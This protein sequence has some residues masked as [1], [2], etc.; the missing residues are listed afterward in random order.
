[1]DVRPIFFKDEAGNDSD[2]T[3]LKLNMYYY[4]ANLTSTHF[5]SNQMKLA[6]ILIPLLFLATASADLLQNPDFEVP[7]SNLPGNSSAP[8]VLLNENNT[9]PGW[10]FE[11]TVQ[12][13]TAGPTVLLPGNG[14]AIE[15]GQDGMINQTFTANSDL[16]QYLLTFTLAL[17]GQ[18]C[19]SNASLIVSAPDSASA[20]S[21]KQNYG[22]ET[23]ESYGHYLGSWGNGET[24][25]LVFQSQ[26]T[27][28]DNASNCWP[29]VDTLLLKP[30]R[31]LLQGNDNL[32]LNGGFELGPQ[33]LNNS[34]EGILLEPEPSPVQSV[35]Q[36]WSVTGTVKYI[37]SKHYFVPEG[38][39][40][41]EIVS[42]VS[43]GIQTARP[44]SEGS[45]YNLEF[46]LGDA[47]DSCI[48]DFT[49]GVQAGS[50]VQNFT[51]LSNGTGSAKKF[52]VTFKAESSPTPISFLSYTT[53]QTQ[54]RAFC[55]PVIDDVVLRA[56]YGLK[57]CPWN[58]L[59]I[60]CILMVVLQINEKLH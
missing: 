8:F 22:K 19:T 53:S 23:W 52:S 2:P 36:Q 49:I 24:I 6:M 46:M 54:D 34:S 33:F 26:T 58:I 56:S 30:V 57:P 60:T 51:L 10:S 28:S 55:G 42:G 4:K 35:L 13:V 32:L 17:G 50:T 44:L 15:L 38:N 14:H 3:S 27:E 31:T 37:D 45:A 40:A 25:N 12:Y 43:A 1:M 48:G 5:L 39:A 29:V 16:M 20:F 59:L 7:P 18:N 21:L 11:G 9:I 41:I 47:N